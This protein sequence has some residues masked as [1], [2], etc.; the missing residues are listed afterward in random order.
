[1]NINH[2]G[3]EGIRRVSRQKQTNGGLM[4]RKTI[5]FLL[6]LFL[7][8]AFFLPDA[9][10]LAADGYPDITGCQI[11]SSGILTWDAY[12][13]TAFYQINVAGDDRWGSYEET[14][15][16]LNTLFRDNYFDTGVYQIAITAYDEEDRVLAVSAPLTFGFQAY[17]KMTAPK[18]VYWDGTTARWSAVNGAD[19]YAVKIIINDDT[20]YDWKILEEGQTYYDYSD[21]VIHA[22]Y[23]YQFAVRTLKKGYNS[24]DPAYSGIIN[25]W[26]VLGD[27]TVN[28]NGDIL[29]WEPY[30]DTKGREADCYYVECSTN[31]QR[32]YVETTSFNARTWLEELGEDYGYYS[33]TVRALS[34]EGISVSN[35]SNEVTYAFGSQEEFTVTVHNGRTANGVYQYHPGDTVTVTADEERNGQLFGSWLTDGDVSFENQY[36]LTTTFTM[37]LKNVVV[38]ADYSP[39]YRIAVHASPEEGGTVSFWP[40][41]QVY[42]NNYAGIKATPNTGWHFVKWVDDVTG[43]DFAFSPTAN[44]STANGIYNQSYTAIFEQDIYSAVLEP[45][46]LGARQVGY[47]SVTPKNPIIT[48]TGTMRLRFDHSCMWLTGDNADKFELGYNNT[49]SGSFRPGGPWT[50]NWY[51][52][53]K[54]GLTLFGVNPTTTYTATLVFQDLDKK[55]DPVET[56]VSFTVTSTS[57]STVTFDSNGKGGEV[58]CLTGV[59]GNTF[60]TFYANEKRIIPE[61]ENGYVFD[62]WYRDKACSDDKRVDALNDVISR[63]TTFYAHW[64]E[65]I[66][67]VNLVDVMPLF[68]VE[69]GQQ[70]MED[71]ADLITLEVPDDCDST[72]EAE[73]FYRM[74]NGVMEPY[75]GVFRDAEQYY[76]RLMIFLDRYSDYRFAYDVK[77]ESSLIEGYFMNGTEFEPVV[78]DVTARS[79]TLYVPMIRPSLQTDP[80]KMTLRPGES[81]TVS[82]LAEPNSLSYPIVA[83][84]SDDHT[85]A[86]VKNDGTVTAQAEGETCIWVT[87]KDDHGYTHGEAACLVTVSNEGISLDKASANLAVG[88]TLTLKATL[89]PQNTPDPDVTWSSSDPKVATVNSSGKVTAKKVGT[90]VITATLKSNGATASCEVRVLFKDV[91]K[92]S[93]YFFNPVYWAVENGITTGYTG[94]Q[95]GYFGPNDTC[96]RAQIVTFLWRAAGSPEVD[97]EGIASF[98]DVKKTDYFYKAVLWAAKSNIT[99][100][101]TDSHGNPTGK[102]GSEDKCTRGQVVTFLWRAAG[103]PVVDPS[104]VPSFSDVKTGDFFYKAVLWAAKNNITT[105]YTDSNGNLTGQFGSN[106]GCTRGQV[107]TFLYR[108]AAL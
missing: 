3:I 66:T 44:V 30:V 36:A 7:L 13:G 94:D 28:L 37:P 2:N 29:S 102:F 20:S 85:V 108:A 24:S 105:G 106:D 81:K 26:L 5:S 92:T 64:C 49:P 101:Y 107:V 12:P 45:I 31:W 34:E 86:T 71:L 60:S 77:Q 9:G 39:T 99:T 46:D 82:Y 56:T 93:D 84:S 96:T 95:A 100:G 83:F 68:H 15:A 23:N 75:S 104:G 42:P 18:T 57:L 14:S 97:P 67:T 89:V 19:A 54:N 4:M 1:M 59:T 53:P 35:T 27:L 47:T 73:G 38:T 40:D 91:A 78:E 51:V 80:P 87:V 55:M 50:T 33:F 41:H 63:D 88:K 98:K 10:V 6:C 90:A 16:D 61:G 58:P 8:V 32:F 52:R 48:N 69:S 11:D 76:L 70:Y 79:I 25:G 74:E 17:M 103:S 43:D 62:W 72:V 22:D 21:R 65:A